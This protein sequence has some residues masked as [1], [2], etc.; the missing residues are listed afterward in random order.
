MG[1]DIHVR[2]VKRDRE[3]NEW[4]QV[5]LYTKEKGKF[6][7]AHVYPFRDYELFDILNESEDD[8]YSAKIIITNDLPVALK[9]EI[10]TARNILGNYGF[11]E[12]T[13][14]DLKLYLKE[15]PKVRDYDYEADDPVNAYKDN[16]MKLFIE[17]LEFYIDF[18]DP[19]WDYMGSSSDI[20]ILYWFDC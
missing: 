9:K 10:E 5:K 18:Y 3:T 8:K 7:L 6:K 13:L 15:V 11:K 2:I 14:A 4:K 16:P 20:R 19:Y 1:R 12:N 17:Y